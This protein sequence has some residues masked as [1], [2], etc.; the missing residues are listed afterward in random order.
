MTEFA[1]LEPQDVHE[2]WAHEEYE[3]T[4]WVADEIGADEP[5]QLENTLGIDL[6]VIEQEKS[7]GKYSVDIYAEVVDDGRTV[8]IENQLG[9]S[10]HDH[11]G[12]AI[13]YAA[14]LD[15]DIIVWIAPTFNDEH[16]DAIQGRPH[17]H[18][19]VFPDSQRPRS[20][21]RGLRRSGVLTASE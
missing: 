3:F 13:A 7:V 16:L 12:K 11:L 9:T 20:P 8:I 1:A 14:G 10:D 19:G 15:A 17:R 5:S 21:R 18:P 6:E 2:Y 4:P